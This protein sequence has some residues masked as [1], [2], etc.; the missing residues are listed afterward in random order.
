MINERQW[1]IKLILS[2][3]IVAAGRAIHLVFERSNHDGLC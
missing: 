2:Y 3:S 1:E